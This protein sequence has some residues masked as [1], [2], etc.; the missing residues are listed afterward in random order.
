MTVWVVEDY[1][2]DEI[3]ESHVASICSSLQKAKEKVILYL[4][5]EIKSIEDELDCAEEDEEEDEYFEDEEELRGTLEDYKRAIEQ[6]SN[7][8]CY[9]I[10]NYFD[11]CSGAYT[12]TERIID[13]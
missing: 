4:E 10:G 2:F 7:P 13:K 1:T 6:L 5:H 8:E 3:C 11:I 9:S 12:I